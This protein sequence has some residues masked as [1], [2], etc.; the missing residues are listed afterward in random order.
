M[1]EQIKTE[2]YKKHL[3]DKKEI[4]NNAIIQLKKEFIGIDHVIDQIANAIT[5]WFSSLR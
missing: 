5:S 4:L 1:M 3:F 2:Q